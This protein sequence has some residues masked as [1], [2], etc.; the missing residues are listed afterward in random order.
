MAS[1][2]ER[3]ERYLKAR[4]ATMQET[5]SPITSPLTQPHPFVTISRQAGAGGHSLATAL[6]EEFA[7]QDDT[8]VFGGWRIFDQELCHMVAGDE[9]FA[10]ELEPLINE[11]YRSSSSELVRQLLRP[12]IDQDTVMNRVFQVVRAVAEM[13]KTIILGRAGS[14]VTRDLEL[15]VSVRLIAPMHSRL[16]RLAATHSVSAAKA[17]SMAKKLDAQRS[18]LL[19]AHFGADIDDPLGYDVTFNTDH[20]A[21][22]GIAKAIAAIVSHRAEHA[23][24]VDS[25]QVVR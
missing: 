14:E 21:F 12:G 4:M 5:D 19:R 24:S 13:G 22:D 25:A 10:A 1:E 15:G 17:A 23:A 6:L 3:V 2:F 8:E 9:R 11:E 7:T 16:S 20:L 18:R